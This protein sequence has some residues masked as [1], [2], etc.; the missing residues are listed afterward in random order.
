MNSTDA[1]SPEIFFIYQGC[2]K[3]FNCYLPWFIPPRQETQIVEGDKESTSHLYFGPVENI[4]NKV[5]K[6]KL[7]AMEL[8]IR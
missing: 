5:W 7:P 1:N 2:C 4:R 8:K 3:P 6:C